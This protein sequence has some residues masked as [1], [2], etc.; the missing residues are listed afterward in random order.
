MGAVAGAGRGL[1]E[2]DGVPDEVLRHFSQRRAEIEQRAAEL[3]GAGAAEP[4]SRER[5]QGIALATR[6]PKT[7]AASTARRGARRRGRAPP[8]TA[9]A[10]MSLP[11][12]RRATGPEQ[13]RRSLANVVARLSG[14]EGLTGTHNTFARRQAVAEIAGEFVDGALGRGSGARDRPLPL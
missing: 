9:S 3:V 1:F 6:R 8:S 12:A 10:P 5:M 14:A 13:A 11:G 4:L 7:D 2:I